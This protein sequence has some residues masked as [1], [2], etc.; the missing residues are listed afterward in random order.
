MVDLGELALA[1]ETVEVNASFATVTSGLAA[2]VRPFE[3]SAS[4]SQK[5]TS[6]AL[7]TA[8]RASIRFLL[9]TRRP[10]RGPSYRCR[11]AMMPTMGS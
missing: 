4:R 10:A 2:A 7:A 5:E 8:Q 3:R 9:V 1:V 6:H 11:G